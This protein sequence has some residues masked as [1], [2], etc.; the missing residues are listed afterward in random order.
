[1]TNSL[2]TRA[3][4]VR[5][6]VLAGQYT[7]REEPLVFSSFPAE[8]ELV[9]A[10]VRLGLPVSTGT[11]VTIRAVAAEPGVEQWRFERNGVQVTLPV[12]LAFVVKVRG[13]GFLLAETTHLCRWRQPWK[14]LVETTVPEEDFRLWTG[15]LEVGKMVSRLHS[16]GWEQGELTVRVSVKGAFALKLY[17]WQ[18]VWA[19]VTK[20]A[21][22]RSGAG[23]S[24]PV[25]LPLR[26]AADQRAEPPASPPAKPG[27]RRRHFV[28][29]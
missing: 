19:Q 7:A 1:M 16:W 29:G 20:G 4:P 28:L 5:L 23:K 25:V 11:P 17:V 6:Q 21:P 27:S 18:D 13:G 9:P 24:Q 15:Y 14:K 3:V 12:K 8:K 26:P 10:C 22:S 2:K